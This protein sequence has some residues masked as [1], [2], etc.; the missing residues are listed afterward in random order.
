MQ[1][2]WNKTRMIGNFHLLV[3]TNDVWM[4]LTFDHIYIIDPS[5]PNQPQRDSIAS[6][7]NNSPSLDLN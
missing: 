2:L 1:D 5:K 7:K 6:A 4:C 3:G